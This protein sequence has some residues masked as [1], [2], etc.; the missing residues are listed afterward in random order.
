MTRFAIR[1]LLSRK[2]RTAL[3]AIAIVLGVAMIS[4]TYVLTD[5]IDQAFDRSSRTS[6]RARARSSPASRRSTS[7]TAAASPSRRSTSRCSPRCATLPGVAR[8]RGQ[9]RLGRDAAHRRRREGG[10][11]RRRAEPRLLDRERRLAVQPADA[12]R[13]RVARAGR[14]RRRQGDR[15]ASRT[16]RSARRSA[17]RRRARSSSC[18]SPESS[19]FSSG[20]DD[21]R[22]DARRL[23]PPDRAAALQEG[24]PARRDRGRREARRDRRELVRQIEAILPPG[25]QVKTGSE[26]AQ[27]DAAETSEF[28]SFLRGSC[29]RSAASRSSSARS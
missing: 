8:G 29:S 13:R 10:R 16:S 6:A 28:I 17:F 20:L 11:L 3:T 4:G 5:S 23:R 21:R 18:G 25:A 27:A 7:P 9:R 22:R 2:L 26:Q 1:G 12:R 24:G 15:R 14:G 19:K